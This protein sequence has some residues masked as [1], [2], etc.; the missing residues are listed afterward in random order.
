MI[1]T[2]ASDRE[3]R[4]LLCPVDQGLES[5]DPSQIGSGKGFGKETY[6]IQATCMWY[7][8]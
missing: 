1:T 7:I 6:S 2:G 8:V 5:R 4:L 3:R